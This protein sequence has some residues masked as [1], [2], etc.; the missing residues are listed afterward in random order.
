MGI[1]TLHDLTVLI[2]F[3]RLIFSVVHTVVQ[4]IF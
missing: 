3:F 4:T 1:Q 2:G